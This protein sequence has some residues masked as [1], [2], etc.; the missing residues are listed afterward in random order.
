MK[1]GLSN[2]ETVAKHINYSLSTEWY[3]SCYSIF[4]KPSSWVTQIHLPDIHRPTFEFSKIVVFMIHLC[5]IL[6]IESIYL[7]ILSQI[8]SHYSLTFVLSNDFNWDAYELSIS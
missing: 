4:I 1:F 5:Y 3:I 8:S 2:N 7:V 6:S